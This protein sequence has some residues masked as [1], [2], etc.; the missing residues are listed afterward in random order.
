MDKKNSHTHS[1]P[2]YYGKID[3]VH[4]FHATAEDHKALVGEHIESPDEDALKSAISKAKDNKSATVVIHGA[5]PKSLRSKI[6]E[7]LGIAHKLGSVNKSEVAPVRIFTEEDEWDYAYPVESELL[8]AEESEIAKNPLAEHHGKKVKVYFNLHKKLYS[9]QHEGK[10]IAH[11]KHVA[12]DNPTFKVSEAGRQRVL[13]EGQKNVH[14]FVVGHLDGHHSDFATE[15]KTR[16]S[17]NPRK[18]SHFVESGTANPIASAKHATMSIE[19]KHENGETKRIPH[20]HTT[21]PKA[22]ENPELKKTFLQPDSQTKSDI[23]AHVNSLNSLHP[24]L[25]AWAQEKLV[26][27]PK[28]ATEAI[29]LAGHKIKVH[30][31]DAD[32]YSGWIVDHEGNKVHQFERLG[33]PELM[34]QIQ[35][36][37]EL[38]GKEEEA[39]EINPAD[40]MAKIKSLHDRIREYLG[41]PDLDL[42]KDPDFI[43]DSEAAAK[44]KEVEDSSPKVEDRVEIPAKELLNQSD[45]EQHCQA[46]EMPDDSCVCFT[47]L[48]KPHIEVDYKTKKITILFKSEWDQESRSSFIEDLKERGLK[49]LRARK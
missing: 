16:V 6:N 31:Y 42:N 44:I 49:I 20:I 22:L 23:N 25:K 14:A 37:L 17:Y 26:S 32:L 38:Y 28:N 15:G 2:H 4:V 43:Q 34:A 12:V 19:D 30:K 18:G 1:K 33:M 40:I 3:Q 8:K 41:E 10:V 47:G 48:P 46:C 39:T 24:A 9:I 5:P 45:E 11:A 7:D 13:K 21:E 29:E 27:L 36:K 35:S